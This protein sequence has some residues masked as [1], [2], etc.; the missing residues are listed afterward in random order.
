MR[1]FTLCLCLTGLACIQPSQAAA[2]DDLL[3]QYQQQGA[4][5]FNSSAGEKFWQQD[6]NGKR[7]TQCHGS[8][9]QQT[10]QHSQTHKNIAPMA[11]SVNAQRLT[12]SAKIE[13]WFARNCKFTLGR[14]CTPQEKGNVLV[15]LRGQ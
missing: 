7:C 4:G 5:A 12:D 9:P 13:K 15:W 1:I 8:T 11:P 14:E 10:G 6:F 3:S 2:V